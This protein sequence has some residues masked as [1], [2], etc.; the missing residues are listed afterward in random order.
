MDDFFFYIKPNFLKNSEDILDI[1]IKKIDVQN[2][3]LLNNIDDFFI[4]NIYGHYK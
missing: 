3:F 4:E 2:V 1:F